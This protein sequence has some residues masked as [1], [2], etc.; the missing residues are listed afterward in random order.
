MLAYKPKMKSI[1]LKN[2]TYNTP[3]D[4]YP[5]DTKTDLICEMKEIIKSFVSCVSGLI[6]NKNS[7]YYY[8]TISRQLKGIEEEEKMFVVI[9]ADVNYP[10]ESCDECFRKIEEI[11]QSSE[12]QANNS[13]ISQFRQQMYYL[14]KEY[15]YS[16]SF[17][18]NYKYKSGVINGKPDSNLDKE[19][20]SENNIKQDL[21]DHEELIINNEDN[22]KELSRSIINK[23]NI[24]I[25]YNNFQ[26]RISNN[27]ENI[28][29]DTEKGEEKNN[30][31]N[32]YDLVHQRLKPWKTIKILYL[33]LCLIFSI[34]YMITIL[35][36]S[37]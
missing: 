32:K 28:I 15:V 34:S 3:A 23:D 17:N 4:Y 9:L 24:S 19:I 2:L 12:I 5:K 16:E 13:L 25:I 35:F 8:N 27:K 37:K 20:D 21:L 18:L 33:F 22:S 1:M 31:L 26:E 36:L 11:F 14:V 7:L 30:A 29:E 10:E 6:E